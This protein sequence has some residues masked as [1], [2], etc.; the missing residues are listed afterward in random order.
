MSLDLLIWESIRAAGL[1]AYSLLALSVI[2]GLGIRTRAFDA[3]FKR[4]WVNEFHQS[5]SVAAFVS[6]VI[7][8]VLVLLNSHVR[9][10]LV[11][12][13]V[14]FTSAWEP[15]AVTMGVL[16]MY[17]VALLVLSSWARPIIG[18][19]TWRA[20]HYSSF[21]AWLSALGHGIFAGT[22]A[23]VSWVF[24]LYLGSAAAV[25]F[26]FAYRL[27]APPSQQSAPAQTAQA[28]PHP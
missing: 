26:M 8:V 28:R 25:A 1:L 27:L 13:F 23:G 17:L 19:K 18:Q 16:G 24:Y 22:D 3:F 21:F 12:V 7:H 20:L 10:S 11:E 9:F 2:L 4:G 14:P 15:L 6:V 5:L